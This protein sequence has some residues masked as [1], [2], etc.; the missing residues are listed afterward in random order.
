M[1]KHTHCNDGDDDGE[2]E[3]ERELV[4]LRTHAAG[5]IGSKQDAEAPGCMARHT[6]IVCFCLQMAPYMYCTTN[7]R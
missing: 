2:R 5:L 7:R 3:R 1:H 6:P 4:V